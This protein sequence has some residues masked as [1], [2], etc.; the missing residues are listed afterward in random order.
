MAQILMFPTPAA[1]PQHHVEPDTADMAPDQAE[2]LAVFERLMAFHTETQRQMA[3]IMT[4]GGQAM[5][6]Q[7]TA[8][9]VYYP[10]L[11]AAQA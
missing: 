6:A 10:I 7:P 11:R 3:D 8:E 2:A 1:A 4:A 9:V 5:A